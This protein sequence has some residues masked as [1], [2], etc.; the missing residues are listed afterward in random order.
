MTPRAAAENEVIELLGERL[1]AYFPATAIDHP[2]IWISALFQRLREAIGS[3]DRVAVSIA[4]ELIE[5][6]PHL[7]FGKLIKS[8]LSRELRKSPHVLVAVER[9]QVINATLCLLALPHTPRELED[10]TK[11]LSKLPGHEY[12]ERLTLVETQNEKSARMKEY[13][14]EKCLAKNA[15]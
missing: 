14:L 6:D 13:L 10:Y 4:C 7:P 15:G 12:L 11:L 9:S 8:G 2:G 5:K 3:G 1:R